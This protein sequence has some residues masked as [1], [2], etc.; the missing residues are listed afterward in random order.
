MSGTRY[1]VV[2]GIGGAGVGTIAVTAKDSAAGNNTVTTDNSVV[3]VM[4]WEA[5][6]V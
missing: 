3:D 2:Y 5:A 4:T 1:A 6:A